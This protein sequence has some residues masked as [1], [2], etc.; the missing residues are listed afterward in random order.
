VVSSALLPAAPAIEGSS[1]VS[2][3]ASHRTIVYWDVSVSTTAELM[4]R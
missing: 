3:S 2:R 1:P 4:S